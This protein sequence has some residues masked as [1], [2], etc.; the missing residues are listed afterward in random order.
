MRAHGATTMATKTTIAEDI[1][2]ALRARIVR[3]EWAPGQRLPGE[4]ELAEA[5][6]TNRN[7]LREAVRKLEQFGLVSVRQGQGA[8]VCDWRKTG[9]IQLLEPF[10]AHGN[11]ANEKVQLLRDLLT[12]RT[13]VLESAMSLAAE[14]ATDADLERLERLTRVL[15]A[16]GVAQDREALAEGYQE[17]LEAL[18]DASHSLAARWSA[19]PFLSMNQSLMR[20]FPALWVSDEAFGEYLDACTAALR[21]RDTDAGVA[22]TRRYYARIDSVVLS[23]LSALLPMLDGTDPFQTPTD[24]HAPENEDTDGSRDR[25]QERALRREQRRQRRSDKRARRKSGR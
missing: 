21:A 2:V 23:A 4:R 19:N 24:A 9:T 3:G 13:L 12:F 10:L 14:R 20:R 17:W 7:T 5:Y 1:F 16:A 8:T 18:V 11:D 25:I 6:E 22:A 15:K